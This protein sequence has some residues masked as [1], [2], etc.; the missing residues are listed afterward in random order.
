MY[1]PIHPDTVDAMHEEY[2]PI[3]LT[4]ACRIYCASGPGDTVIVDGTEDAPPNDL[5][6]KCL[7]GFSLSPPTPL[8]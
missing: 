6:S 3:L 1:N 4:L 8:L 5:S 7:V 2:P